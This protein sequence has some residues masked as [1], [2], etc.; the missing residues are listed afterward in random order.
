MQN[1]LFETVFLLPSA[2]VRI[3]PTVLKRVPPFLAPSGYK[4]CRVKKAYNT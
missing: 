2:T 1:K 3:Q 4:F